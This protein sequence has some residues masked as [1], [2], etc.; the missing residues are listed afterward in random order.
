MILRNMNETTEYFIPTLYFFDTISNEIFDENIDVVVSQ[1]K[2]DELFDVII[3]SI[4][5]NSIEKAKKII[6]EDFNYELDNPVE[7]V[8]QK[9]LVVVDT[10]TSKDDAIER[11]KLIYDDLN[12][13]YEA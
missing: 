6:E 8:F 10:F 1:P 5:K 12:R 4:D 9:Y 7:S 3:L 2:Y 11:A 13:Y